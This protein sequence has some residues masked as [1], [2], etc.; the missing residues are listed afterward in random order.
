MMRRR[1][2]LVGEL[3]SDGGVDE[4][5]GLHLL[6]NLAAIERP[7]QCQLHVQVRCQS[8][9]RRERE[10]L[11][12]GESCAYQRTDPASIVVRLISTFRHV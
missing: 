12:D 8:R 4:G 10:V 3:R 9:P 5:F 11:V 7:A 2:L 6:Q 1:R